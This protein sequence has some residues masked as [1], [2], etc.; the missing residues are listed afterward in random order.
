MNMNSAVEACVD[1]VSRGHT[2]ESVKRVLRCY[3]YTQEQREEIMQ[4]VKD[5]ISRRK[6]GNAA[7]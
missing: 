1:F 2:F 6:K 5:E 7:C 4:K 3:G